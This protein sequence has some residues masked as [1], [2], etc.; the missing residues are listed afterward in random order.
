MDDP[1][2]LAEQRQDFDEDDL[3]A[4][5]DSQVLALPVGLKVDA[6]GGLGPCRSSP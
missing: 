5:A 2:Q 4:V 6:F 1:K 3:L